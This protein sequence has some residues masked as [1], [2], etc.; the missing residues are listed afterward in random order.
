MKLKK[1]LVET[2]SKLQRLHEKDDHA[3]V[4]KRHRLD[5]YLSV[6]TYLSYFKKIQ[7]QIHLKKFYLVE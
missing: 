4:E 6:S 3:H 7:N 2:H 1:K 5:T